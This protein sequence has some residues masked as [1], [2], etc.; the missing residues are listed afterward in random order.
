MDLVD[1]LVQ[2]EKCSHRIDG[3]SHDA[4]FGWKFEYLLDDLHEPCCLLLLEKG[5]DL[6][7]D[8]QFDVK[9]HYLFLDVLNQHVYEA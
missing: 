4:L 1:K 6:V 5:V 8:G 7:E 3:H 2:D 9:H